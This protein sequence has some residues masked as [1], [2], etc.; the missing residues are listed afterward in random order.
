MLEEDFCNA[1]EAN[2]DTPSDSGNIGR[3]YNQAK[4]LYNMHQDRDVDRRIN[5]L[6]SGLEIILTAIGQMRN[7]SS[8]SHGVGDRRINLKEHHARLFMNAAM[9][10]ADFILS[11]EKKR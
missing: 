8:N 3:L 11:V 4:T 9:T 1:I 2:G 5:G 6:L 7:E 10:M